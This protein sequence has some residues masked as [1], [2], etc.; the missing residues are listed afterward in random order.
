MKTWMIYGANGYTGKLTA[1]EAVRRRAHQL[2]QDRGF[3]RRPLSWL[4]AD[5]DL[6]LGRAVFRHEGVELQ[7]RGVEHRHE[8]AG[9]GAEPAKGPEGIA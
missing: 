7:A 1:A 4:G 8:A 6:A 9:Q 3:V 2:A 5:G